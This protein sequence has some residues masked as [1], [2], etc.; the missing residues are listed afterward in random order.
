MY[1]YVSYNYL[2]LQF[3]KY[4]FK[5]P[6]FYGAKKPDTYFSDNQL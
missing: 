3:N 1:H 4:Y 2:V 5:K 6:I